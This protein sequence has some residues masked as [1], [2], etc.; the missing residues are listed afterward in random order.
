MEN[1]LCL[2]ALDFEDLLESILNT[3]A[4]GAHIAVVT[5]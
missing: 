2:T 1:A 4:G 5:T 3:S